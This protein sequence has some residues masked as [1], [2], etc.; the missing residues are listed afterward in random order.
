MQPTTFTG[1]VGQSGSGKSTLVKLLPRL[2]K[3]SKGRI[4]IDGYDISKVELYS[5]RRQVGIVPQDPLLFKGTVSENICLTNP[6]ASSDEIIEA[7]K[8]A[9]AHDFIMKLPMGYSTDVGERGLTCRV[10]NAKEWR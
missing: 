5:L 1:I 3:P 4:L 9:D 10:A 6:D 7:A 2:Y 8:V